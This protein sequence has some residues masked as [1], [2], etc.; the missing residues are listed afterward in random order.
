MQIFEAGLTQKTQR[1]N[2][3]ECFFTCLQKAMADN[4]QRGA[5]IVAD[6]ER[7]RRQVGCFFNSAISRQKTL[8]ETAFNATHINNPHTSLFCCR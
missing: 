4:Q 5:Q 3:V 8:T 1:Q 6:F 7:S 2:E